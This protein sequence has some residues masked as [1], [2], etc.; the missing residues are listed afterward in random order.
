M[1]RADSTCPH[2]VKSARAIRCRPRQATHRTARDTIGYT[3]ET[4]AGHH[5]LGQHLA[6]NEIFRQLFYLAV[7][8]VKLHEARKTGEKGG[9]GDEVGVFGD[10]EVIEIGHADMM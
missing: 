3:A 1:S 10:A 7:E 2:C 4:V 9:E 8:R 5:E 6:A